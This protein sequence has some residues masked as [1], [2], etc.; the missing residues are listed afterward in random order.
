MIRCLV[1]CGSDALYQYS[2]QEGELKSKQAQLQE[3]QN[4]LNGFEGVNKKYR[5]QLIKVKVGGGF[6]LSPSV[7]Y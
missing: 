5:D 6:P 3:L 2:R 7:T 1:L 4:D